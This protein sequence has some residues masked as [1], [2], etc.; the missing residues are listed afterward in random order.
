TGAIES[1]P[2]DKQLVPIVLLHTFPL[3]QPF[4]NDDD[5]GNDKSLF[6]NEELFDSFPFKIGVK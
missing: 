3:L 4:I 1:I 6:V 2:F 5:D